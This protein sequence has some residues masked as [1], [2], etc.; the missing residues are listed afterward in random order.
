MKVKYYLE[1]KDADL[2]Y[3]HI[4][5]NL[6]SMADFAKSFKMHPSSLSLALRCKRPISNELAEYVKD[7]KK[8][9]KNG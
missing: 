7:I 9:V 3:Q 6:L 8:C 4:E 5:Q 1:P 2:L